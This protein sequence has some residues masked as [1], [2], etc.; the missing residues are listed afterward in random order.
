MLSMINIPGHV[1]SQY[2]ASEIIKHTTHQILI[3]FTFT[4]AHNYSTWR[5]GSSVG[6]IVSLAGFGGDEPVGYI[7][8]C[9]QDS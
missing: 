1:P 7:I 4:V 6:S 8:G 5:S 2:S 9:D 3:N